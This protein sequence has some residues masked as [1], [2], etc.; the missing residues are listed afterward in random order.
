M[1]HPSLHLFAS[2]L[3]AAIFA[4]LIGWGLIALGMAAMATLSAADT[5]ALYLRLVTLG[6]S[7]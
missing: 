1:T 3:G 5:A 6:A 2:W 4:W 7:P